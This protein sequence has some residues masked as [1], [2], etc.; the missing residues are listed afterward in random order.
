MAAQPTKNSRWLVIPIA[1]ISAAETVALR[2]TLRQVATV[3]MR[4]VLINEAR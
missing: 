2:S 3:V 1:A 4:G